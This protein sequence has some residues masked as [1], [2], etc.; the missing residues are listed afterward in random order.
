[1]TFSLRVRKVKL[2]KHEINK[3]VIILIYLLSINFVKVKIIA[4]IIKE[5]HLINELKVK[6]LINNNI[7]N[8]KEIFINI[9]Q[10]KT[11]INSY[12]ITINV[13][14]KHKNKYIH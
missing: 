7:L 6:M 3:Y 4:F 1:M 12:K 8:L 11:I 10:K 13:F 5:L 9:A 2:I 14:I